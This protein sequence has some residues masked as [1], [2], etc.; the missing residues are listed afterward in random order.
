V[1]KEVQAAYRRNRRNNAP[2]LLRL[3]ASGVI[4]PAIQR[5]ALISIL[6][7]AAYLLFIPETT[8]PWHVSAR[9]SQSAVQTRPAL[10]S[11]AHLPTTAS[12]APLASSSNLPPTAGTFE[13]ISGLPGALAKASPVQQAA[14]NRILAFVTTGNMKEIRTLGTN[15]IQSL[16]ELLTAELGAEAVAA[17]VESYFGLPTAAFLAHGNSAQALTDLFTAVQSESDPASAAPLVFSDRVEADGT[18]TGN[19]HVIPPGTKR[20]YA[21]FE[22]SG[23]L[24]GLDRVLAVWRNPSNDRLVFTEYEPVHAGATFNH[25]WLELEDGWPAGF[26]RLDLFHPSQNDRLLASRSFNVR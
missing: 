15:D 22:N 5:I 16:A 1:H 8:E 4:R 13:L 26:Y 25:V 20:I 23:T 24:Q 11:P 18:V 21:A 2:K 14:A 19:V 6:G 9:R 17:A 12:T 10:Q 7:M 3:S